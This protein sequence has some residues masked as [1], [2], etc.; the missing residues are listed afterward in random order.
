MKKT[1]GIILGAVAFVASLTACSSYVLTNSESYVGADLSSYHTFRLVTPHDGDLP[2]GMSMVSY[3]NIAAAIREQ[4]TERGFTEDPNS[5][6]LVNIGL[7]VKKQLVNV[8]VTQ[9]VQT[10]PAV[11]P[12]PV[13]VP[14]PRPLPRPVHPGIAPGSGAPMN[15]VVPVFMYPRS[16]YWPKYTTVTQWV[17]TI[18]KEGVLTMDLVNIDK[19]EPVYT[20]SVATILDNGDNELQTLSGITKAVQVLFSKFPVPMQ[21]SGK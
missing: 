15:G 6:L 17:P 19:E 2:P 20:A 8:P 21:A 10:G 1:L 5:P 13:P 18:Y 4:M 7:T 16:Y 9:T 3:Y 12:P 14:A 11:P